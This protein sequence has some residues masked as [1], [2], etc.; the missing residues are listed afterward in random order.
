MWGTQELVGAVAISGLAVAALAGVGAFFLHRSGSA[1]RVQV[2]E[3]TARLEKLTSTARAEIST[4]RHRASTDVSNAKSFALQGFATDLL[5]V[6]DNL[7]RAET[8]SKEG[9]V[10]LEGVQMTRSQLTRVLNKHGVARIDAAPGA[11]FDVKVH[12][13]V[14][15]VPSDQPLGTVAELAQEGYA[16]NGRVFRPAIVVVSEGAPGGTDEV[17]PLSSAAAWKVSVAMRDHWAR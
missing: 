10:G 9:Q 1:S 17:A 6:A 12:E 15:N 7:E 2:G 5:E 13:A 14:A 8:S 4:A 16:L 3:L 11:K